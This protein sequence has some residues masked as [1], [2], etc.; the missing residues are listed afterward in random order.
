MSK[1][2]KYSPLKFSAE[3]EVDSLIKYPDLQLRL[4]IREM[5]VRKTETDLTLDEALTVLRSEAEYLMSRI[6]SSSIDQQV[7]QL[8]DKDW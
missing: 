6:N 7:Q 2:E 8:K 4:F 5:V 1:V 3:V